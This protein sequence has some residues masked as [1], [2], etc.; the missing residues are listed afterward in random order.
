L[1]QGNSTAAPY[2]QDR[3]NAVAVTQRK[4]A[5]ERFRKMWYNKRNVMAFARRKEK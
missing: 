3:V 1:E 5:I 4:G 2:L